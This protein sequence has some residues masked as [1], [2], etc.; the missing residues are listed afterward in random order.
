MGCGGAAELRFPESPANSAFILLVNEVP[1]DAGAGD[2]VGAGVVD[3]A[4]AGAGGGALSLPVRLPNEEHAVSVAATAAAAA[5]RQTQ[6]CVP[7]REASAL[8]VCRLR[9]STLIMRNLRSQRPL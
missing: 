5:C 7:P 1:D 9:L 2:V 6:H 3:A 4:D 8:P